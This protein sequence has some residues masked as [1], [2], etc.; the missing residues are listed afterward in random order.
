MRSG[1][2]KFLLGVLSKAINGRARELSAARSTSQHS[3][4]KAQQQQA[5]PKREPALRTSIAI[6][7][8]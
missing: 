3:Q 5:P 1:R 2:R 4:H 6:F 8:A 7:D